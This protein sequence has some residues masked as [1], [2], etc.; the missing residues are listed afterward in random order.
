VQQVQAPQQSFGGRY[1]GTRNGSGG[2]QG[3]QVQQNRQTGTWSRDRNNWNRQSGDQRQYSQQAQR[4][5][6]SRWSGGNWNRDWRNDRRY[7]WRNYRDHH[8]SAF[9]LGLYFDPF[10]YG[11]RQF[12]IGYRLTPGYYGQ[13]YWIDPAM[14][15]L[16]YAPPGT[17]WVRYWNDALLVDMYTGEVVDVINNFF[18]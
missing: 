8:R 1:R 12:D 15:G 2:V 5:S 16:P 17:Q 6:G 11:Y 10:G 14:Y 9:H 3:Q 4:S 7:D 13:R 18:W